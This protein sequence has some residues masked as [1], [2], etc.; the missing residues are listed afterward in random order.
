MFAPTPFLIL[1]FAGYGLFIV[2]LM[3]VSIWTILPSRRAR[4]ATARLVAARRP[5][6][7]E[8]PV[9]LAA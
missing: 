6:P 5:H 3:T 4:V 8:T 9:R 1:V 7:I 2:T